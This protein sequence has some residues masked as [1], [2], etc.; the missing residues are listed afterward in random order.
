MT[1]I[2]LQFDNTPKSITVN[3]VP[4]GPLQPEPTPEPEPQPEPTPEPPAIAPAP[5][6][7]TPI[8]T[9]Q[10]AGLKQPQFAPESEKRIFACRPTS[11]AFDNPDLLKYFGVSI[12]TPNAGTPAGK[13]LRDDAPWVKALGYTINHACMTQEDCDRFSGWSKER[14][15]DPQTGILAL[16]EKRDRA[17][18]YWANVF[19]DNYREWAF[20]E[21]AFASSWR[22]DGLQHD[23]AVLDQ[24]IPGVTR[25]A[26]QHAVGSLIREN[27]R[28]NLQPF[29]KA[30]C[31][32]VANYEASDVEILSRYVGGLYLDR[33]FVKSDLNIFNLK[34][35]CID[36]D[37]YRKERFGDDYWSIQDSH[38]SDGNDPKWKMGD[39]CRWLIRMSVLGGW[40]GKHRFA[41]RNND[42]EDFKSGS[43][44]MIEAEHFVPAAVMYDMGEPVKNSAVWYDR[45][46]LTCSYGDSRVFTLAVKGDERKPQPLEPYTLKFSREY[47]FLHFDSW[48]S[49]TEYTL[50]PGEGVVVR[51]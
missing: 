23:K 1:E 4:W 26:H 47:E 10:E 38:A 50:Q 13:Q 16:V 9:F 33:S 32:N 42:A 22:N 45:G 6:V 14:G 44:S 20:Q 8:P 2:R 34:R 28:L 25:D 15:I 37:R 51:G 48:T 40:Q 43:H 21:M 12:W 39:Y 5:P 27:Y 29:G 41:T 11:D 30:C 35:M 24:K 19:D 17:E 7:G 18:K 31:V 49:G 36:N 3:G 46:V